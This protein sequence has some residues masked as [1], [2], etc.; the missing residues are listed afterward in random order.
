MGDG[1]TFVATAAGASIG[2]IVVVARRSC[3]CTGSASRWRAQS[4]TVLSMLEV[5][6]T[7]S[8]ID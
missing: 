1:Y 5:E 7:N 2:T 4:S 6:D 8:S 3:G